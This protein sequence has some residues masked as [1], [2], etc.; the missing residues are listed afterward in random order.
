MADL[1]R[2]YAAPT[3]DIALNQRQYSRRMTVNRI[4]KFEG[5][6][7]AQPDMSEI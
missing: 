4:S 6:E 1:K 2:V 3:E 5:C 7:A